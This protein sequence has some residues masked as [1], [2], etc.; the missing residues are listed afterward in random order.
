MHG[1]DLNGLPPPHIAHSHQMPPMSETGG[2]NH[3]HPDSTDSYVTYLE[4]DDSLHGS[5]P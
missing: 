4:S 1:F 2:P 5:S 3:H